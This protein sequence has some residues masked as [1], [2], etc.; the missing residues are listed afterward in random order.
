MDVVSN[1]LASYGSGRAVLTTAA[2]RRPW[3]IAVD[4]QRG[5]AIHVV[6]DGECWLGLAGHEE[7][8]R[9]TQGD[10]VLVTSGIGHRLSDPPSAA[11][12]PMRAALAARPDT[13]I[14]SAPDATT[15]LCAKYQ[16]DEA[17]PHPMAA[18]MPPVIHLA[19]QEVLANEPLR[20]VLELLRVE[21]Q[22]GRAEAHLIASRLLDSALVLLLRAWIDNRPEGRTEWLGA[23]KDPA[24]ARALRL[25]HEQPAQ[26]WTVAR[27][28]NHA[29]LTRATFARRFVQLVGEPPLAYIARVRMGLAAKALRETR[30]SIAEIAHAIGYESG[31]AFSKAFHRAYGQSP[32]RYRDDAASS[33]STG[34]VPRRTDETFETTMR[35]NKEA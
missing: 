35:A 28:A 1:V 33:A 29:V 18:L 20:L 24:I 19:R 11:V 17:G 23:L 16:L 7:H 22:S 32:G 31:A 8:V 5:S 13:P 10:V 26:A 3:G 30:R 25:I 27:L 21:A 2:L 15:L 12:P 6:L 4:P 14:A 9:L 34:F